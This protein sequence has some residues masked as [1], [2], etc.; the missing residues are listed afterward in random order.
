[1]PLETQVSIGQAKRDISDMV[2]R[3]AYGGARII[4]TSRGRPKAVLISMA[5]YER[6]KQAQ[7]SEPVDHWQAWLAESRALATEILTRRQSEPLD[8]DALWQDTRADLEARA[9]KLPRV[10]WALS[11][12]NAAR[13]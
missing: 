3:V 8:I 10:P 4:L 6:L 12:G 13:Q 7:H 11:A 9:V 1:M 5:D 2:N